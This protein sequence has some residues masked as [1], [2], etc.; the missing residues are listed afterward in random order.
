MGIHPAISVESNSS[1]SRKT[2]SSSF[3]TMDKSI[4]TRSK[5]M[6]SAGFTTTNPSKSL[7]DILS[8]I[9]LSASSRSMTRIRRQAS[10][11]RS[12][13]GISS[14]LGTI[15]KRAN[16]PTTW[17]TR[18]PISVIPALICLRL[19]LKRRNLPLLNTWSSY[20][21]RQ[22]LRFK[23]WKSNNIS[24][25]SCFLKKSSSTLIKPKSMRGRRLRPRISRVRSIKGR[26]K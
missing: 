1:T 5:E 17:I 22:E 26:S 11:G 23:F 25:T 21:K 9:Y 3:S 15:I 13:K 19:R 4:K 8:R 14:I 18:G 16:L 7:R 20:K 24:S 6:A 10:W 12:S 2:T